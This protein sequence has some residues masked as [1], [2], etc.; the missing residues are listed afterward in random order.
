MTYLQKA[1]PANQYPF[2]KEKALDA[3]GHTVDA[4]DLSEANLTHCDV[5]IDENYNQEFVLS[6]EKV[7]EILCHE[8]DTN[9][10]SNYTEEYCKCVLVTGGV[11]FVG[12]HIAEALL[13]EGRKVVV[14][15]IFNSETTSSKEKVENA[16]ILRMTAKKN[17]SIGASISIID[18]DIRDQD[19]V[20]QVVKEFKVTGVIHVGGMVDDRA[21]VKHPE[22][23]IDVN[24]RGTAMLLDALGKC[25][26]KMVVQASTRSVF[27]Q[28]LDNSEKLNEHADRR[29][30]NPY[31]ASKVGADAMAHCYCHLH[32]MNLTLVRIFAT[33]GPRGRPDMIPRILI[34]NIVNDKPIHKFGTGDATRTWIYISDVVAAFLVALKHPQ[35]GYA[36]FNTGAPNSTT[37]NE[38]I[39]CGE[40]VTGKKAIIEHCP[41]P[42]G[43]AH[44]VGHPS[45]DH[46][47]HVLGWEPK[48]TVKEGMRLTYEDYMKRF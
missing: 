16:E 34:E 40:E 26:V 6:N 39:R 28:R 31:G 46:I 42:P 10:Q 43:D 22:V 2:K 17:A 18:G 47:K 35:D 12:S 24:I 3:T 36:E 45:Y 48:I 8:D 41:V 19:K 20:I 13:K 33:Y 11:G 21:S 15:D 25:G 23:F 4:L 29:P 27:G 30:I 38:L 14:Y 9:K 44:T 7:N 5:E 32:G 1:I 37:L